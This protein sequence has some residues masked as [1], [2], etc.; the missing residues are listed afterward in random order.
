M[1][2]S[3]NILI[4]ILIFTMAICFVIFKNIVLRNFF[5]SLSLSIFIKKLKFLDAC[6][7][8]SLENICFQVTKLIT[9]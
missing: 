9:I 5:S 2:E 8:H 7:T 3:Y 4:D 1:V 6:L